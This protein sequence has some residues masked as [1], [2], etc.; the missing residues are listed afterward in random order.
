MIRRTISYILNIFI[1]LLICISLY[2]VENSTNGNTTQKKKKISEIKIIALPKT[3][4]RKPVIHF[5]HLDHVE[6]NFTECIDCHHKLTNKKCSTCH[7]ARDQG[8]LVN[9]KDAYH[10]QCHNCHRETS[11]PKACSLCHIKQEK[12]D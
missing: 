6:K 12:K 10:Q 5:N 1:T 11:G 3:G 4:H 9:L 7:T 2:A 8:A